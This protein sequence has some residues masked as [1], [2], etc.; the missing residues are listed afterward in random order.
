MTVKNSN[1]EE[2]K[3]LDEILGIAKY[4]H[5]KKVAED[6]NNNPDAKLENEEKAARVIDS[7]LEAVICR[8]N[9]L[10]DILLVEQVEQVEGFI[11]HAGYTDIGEDTAEAMTNRFYRTIPTDGTLSFNR[12][13]VFVQTEQIGVYKQGAHIYKIEESAGYNEQEK[14]T[15]LTGTYR[16]IVFLKKDPKGDNHPGTLSEALLLVLKDRHTILNNAYKSNYGGMFNNA[17]DLALLSQNLRY[18]ARVKKGIMGKHIPDAK[19]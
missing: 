1:I 8:V 3:L 18:S 13:F 2:N 19:S 17:I 4:L 14:R 6:L 9:E 11:N 12:P 15:E 16:S 5:S 10:S 7:V